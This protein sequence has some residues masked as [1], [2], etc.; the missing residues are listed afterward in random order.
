[1]ILLII[2][3]ALSACAPIAAPSVPSGATAAETVSAP[4]AT[5][6]ASAVSP[7][8]TVAGAGATFAGTIRHAGKPLGGARIELRPFGWAT[9]GA[10]PVASVTADANGLFTLPDPPAGDWS[11]VGFF[12]DG[13]IDAGGWPPVSIAPGQAVL[14]FVV[15]LERNINLLEPIGGVVVSD[16]PLFAWQPAPGA[17]SYRV[18]VLDAGTTELVVDETTTATTLAPGALP[19]GRPYQWVVNALDAAGEDIATASETF[20]VGA[21]SAATP[22]LPTAADAN[23]LPPSCQPRAGE[24]AAFSSE[25]NT[26]CFLY[27]ERFQA[28]I[29]EGTIDAVGMVVGPALDASPDPLRAIL[30]IEARPAEELDLA[31]AT[32]ALLEE[33]EG[34]P[35]VTL[36][37]R[38]FELGGAPAVL[39]EGVPGRGGSRDILTV[40]DGVRLRLLFMP[41]PAVFPTVQPDLDALF[42]TV[43]QSFT[44]LAAPGGAS[45]HGAMPRL[46]DRDR[47]FAAARAA[48][49][50]RLGIDELS[51][52][53]IEITAQEWSDACLGVSHAGQMCAQVITPGWLITM[54]AGG[55]QYEAHTDQEGAQVRLVDVQ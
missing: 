4:D 34:M 53:L 23:G 46:P 24:F 49:A 6:L 1:L 36:R 27:P 43:T 19:A 25:D 18:W 45:Q 55:R 13:E 2:A 30:V 50:A 15:A 20:Q 9:T 10:A 28:V 14:D 8:A 22:S 12:P 37:Q 42:A 32:A 11:V 52:R 17:A 41:D 39:L 38:P 7:A 51:I 48:L 26:F 47:A 44:F 40:R 29:P 3:L 5:P 33:F 54:E 31:A 16:A 35:G 21:S